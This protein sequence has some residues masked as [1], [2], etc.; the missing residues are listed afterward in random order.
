MIERRHE[1]GGRVSRAMYSRCGGHR[2]LLERRWAPGARLVWVMLNPSTATELSND[3]TIERVER[4][5]RMLGY[6]AL[7][8][9]NLF[10][11]RA[12]RPADLARAE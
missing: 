3:P 7:S 5:S 11:F 8:V 2:Y 9:V 4:R 10:A 12:T 1:G 6:D